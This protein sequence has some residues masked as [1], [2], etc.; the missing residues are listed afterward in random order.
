MF[1]KK[2]LRTL[3]LVLVIMPLNT[4][5]IPTSLIAGGENIGIQI[6]LNGVA[7]A[8]T[9]E[10]NGKNPAIDAGL[11]VGDVI[12]SINGT[13]INSID[14]M[15]NI[16]NN[17]NS[18]V[19]IGFMRKEK[20]MKTNLELINVDGVIKT[21]LYV[22]DSITGI[23]TLSFIDPDTKKFG[24]LGHEI[25]S[26]NTNYLLEIK[27]GKIFES[28]V[29]RIDRSEAGTPGAKNANFY[30]NNVL[31]N[32]SL[33]TTKG[34]FGTYTD[35]LQNKKEYKVADNDEIELG[36]AKILTV[37]SGNEVKEYSINIL[38]LNNDN[39]TNKNIL[40]EIT[41]EELL[42]L[43]GGVVQGMS[44]SPIIQNDYIVGVVNY[45]IVDSPERGYGVFITNMLEKMESE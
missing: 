9:Y 22:K 4:L 8:G 32:V 21:G 45:V 15:V 19:E 17:S 44:G 20:S 6:S 1:F 37:T 40:F 39:S 30:T 23:G 24:A 3:A 10:I 12:T 2:C 26:K 36:S 28:S 38:K 7:I 34:I 5:A 43:T 25:T 31:G 42:S 16:I 14:E 13:K 41:D 35:I 33:N 11:K 27:D 29:T 18:K